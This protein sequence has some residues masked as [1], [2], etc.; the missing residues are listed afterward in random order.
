MRQQSPSHATCAR[1]HKWVI[2]LF[3]RSEREKRRNN[4]KLL[5][6][7]NGCR[8]GARGPP[9]SSGTAHAHPSTANPCGAGLH[10]DGPWHRIIAHHPT[11][12]HAGADR[13]PAPQ[14]PTPPPP[15]K[16]TS[17]HHGTLLPP[18]NAHRAFQQAPVKC[19][20]RFLTLHTPHEPRAARCATCRPRLQGV[21][22][23]LVHPKLSLD[24]DRDG[25]GGG[26]GMTPGCVGVCSW[27]RPLASRHLP[28]PFP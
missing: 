20:S 1:A 24:R 27:R 12:S 7:G 25:G 2:I 21:G 17:P 28:L 16:H 8:T 13:T 18:H 19:D 11:P 14:A 3:R 23:R 5:R 15:P 6:N 9:P 10:R 22:G 4:T 26:V